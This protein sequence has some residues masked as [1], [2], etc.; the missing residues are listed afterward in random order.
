MLCCGKEILEVE[1]EQ[2]VPIKLTADRVLN[3]T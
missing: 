2:S 3:K 1:R